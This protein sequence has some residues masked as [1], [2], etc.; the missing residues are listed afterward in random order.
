MLPE[1]MPL[2]TLSLNPLEPNE[3]QGP[4]FKSTRFS[5]T[6]LSLERNTQHPQSKVGEIYFGS[7]FQSKVGKL[8]SRNRMV[9]RTGWEAAA[10][11]AAR[12]KRET[13]PS[14]PRPQARL[15]SP[16]L[17]SNS[18]VSHKLITSKHTKLKDEG[19]FY[20]HNITASYSFHSFLGISEP[21]YKGSYPG[22]ELHKAL[23]TSRGRTGE[24]TEEGGGV[25]LP[26]G[27]LSPAAP[28]YLLAP[29]HKEHQPDRQNRPA[30]VAK[31]T[32]AERI[33]EIVVMLDHHVLR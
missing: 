13:S 15:T 9:E 1:F 6:S 5:V 3:N 29:S 17:L 25:P 19:L 10:Q 23:A 27:Q 21:F 20:V 16:G 8:Q 22:E 4:S 24:M 32:R 11:P 33:H 18:A 14:G 2:Q 28:P 26:R 12:K 31:R 7:H 30:K